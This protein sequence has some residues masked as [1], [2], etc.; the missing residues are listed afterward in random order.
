MDFGTIIYNLRTDRN[1][2]QIEFA[3][4]IGS[5]QAAITSWERNLSIPHM[6]TIQKIA[7]EFGVPI[8]ELISSSEPDDEVVRIAKIIQ[9]REGLL[10]LFEKAGKLSDQD[11]GVLNSVATAI[12]RA[13]VSP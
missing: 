3:R 13:S 10:S 4:R 2:S 8:E 7:D 12:I 11:I 6:K 9:A 1:L 5:S